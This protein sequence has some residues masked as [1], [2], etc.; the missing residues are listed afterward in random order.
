M[1]ERISYTHPSGRTY[2]ASEECATPDI[3]NVFR[4]VGDDQVYVGHFIERLIGEGQGLTAVK[5]IAHEHE[6]MLDKV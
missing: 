5:V 6:K 1:S 3:V 2:Y 4:G